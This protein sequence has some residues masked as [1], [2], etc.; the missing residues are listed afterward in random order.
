MR[1]L[2][3][4]C[5]L[6]ALALAWLAL[7]PPRRP[8]PVGTAPSPRPATTPSVPPPTTPVVTPVATPSPT[9]TEAALGLPYGVP[10]PAATPPPRV[11]GPLSRAA[12]G[13]LRCAQ[14]LADPRVGADTRLGRVP[15]PCA[16][17]PRAVRGGLLRLVRREGLSALAPTPPVWRVLARL[18]RGG[19]ALEARLGGHATAGG[20][21][22]DLL[23]WEDGLVVELRPVPGGWRATR[24][25]GEGIF[26]R[27]P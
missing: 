18:P 20:R 6:G 4:L 9:P 10:E 24:V 12:D 21:R 19:I 23:P 13:V 2:A 16:P 17:V 27:A 3:I 1:R 14:R 8:H 22:R 26:G 25:S 5:L 15:D 11:I 7:A